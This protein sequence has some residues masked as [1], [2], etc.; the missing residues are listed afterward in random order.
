MKMLKHK[1][2]SLKSSAGLTKNV[3]G[4]ITK[5]IIFTFSQE[6]ISVSK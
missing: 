5:T 4:K 2:I 3:V 6:I 1:N